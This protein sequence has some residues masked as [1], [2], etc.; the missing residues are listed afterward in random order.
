MRTLVE[1]VVREG[2][3]KSA[4]KNSFTPPPPGANDLLLHENK[5]LRKAF[6]TKKRHKNKGKTLNLQQ[7]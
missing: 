4:K 5:G 3:E 7:R 2:E 6:T 1:D